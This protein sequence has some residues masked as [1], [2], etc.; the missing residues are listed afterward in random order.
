LEF[1]V[2]PKN[3]NGRNKKTP[4]M[5]VVQQL[6]I[7][8]KSPFRY[9]QNFNLQNKNIYSC[10]NSIIRQTSQYISNCNKQLVGQFIKAN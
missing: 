8:K 3:G 6:L 9:L 5:R 2:V 4:A 10:Q 1:F 7:A